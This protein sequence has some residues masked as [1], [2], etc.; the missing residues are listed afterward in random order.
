MIDCIYTVSQELK[1][2]GRLVLFFI[3]NNFYTELIIL[4]ASMETKTQSGWL[5]CGNMTVHT[6]KWLGN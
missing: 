6:A 4:L 5:V 3:L 1:A 2:L